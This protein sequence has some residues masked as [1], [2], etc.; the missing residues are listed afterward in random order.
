MIRTL[1]IFSLVKV[2]L[3]ILVRDMQIYFQTCCVGT[4]SKRLWS[5]YM[6]FVIEEAF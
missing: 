2:K 5:I 3:W 6:D 1:E 4:Y